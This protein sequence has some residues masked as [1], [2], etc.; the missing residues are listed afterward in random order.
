MRAVLGWSAEEGWIVK[1]VRPELELSPLAVTWPGATEP[2][3]LGERYDALAMLGYAVVQ[4]GPEAW[5][6]HEGLGPAGQMF[7]AAYAEVRLIEAQELS[8]QP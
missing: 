3:G 4:G 8:T 5:D 7:L 6:W 1:I 2:P